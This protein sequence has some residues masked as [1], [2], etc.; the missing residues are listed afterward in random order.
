METWPEPMLGSIIGTAK[1]ETRS[2]PRES[3]MRNCSWVVAMPTDAGTNHDT[4]AVGARRIRC[5]ESGVGR[6]LLGCDDRELG[7]AI[8]PARVFARH[9]V[10]GFPVADFGGE[11]NRQ[12]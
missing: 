12:S 11:A 3:M 7:V 9:V 4:D 10:V 6:C 2:G 1:G 5:I 8:H